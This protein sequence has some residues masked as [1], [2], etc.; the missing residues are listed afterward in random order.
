M[1]DL[2]NSSSDA[3]IRETL[4][5]LPEGL[6][7]TYKRILTKISKSPS[8]ALARKVFI[9]ATVAKRPLHVEELREAV[10][11]EPDDKSWNEDSIPHEDLMFECC[12]GLIIKDDDETA[13]FAHHTVQQYLTGGLAIKVDPFFQISVVNADIL[14]GQTCVAYLSF[15]DFETQITSSTPTVTPEHKGVLESGGPLWIPSI[16]GIRRPMFDI[17][18]RLLR[19]DP[20]MRPSGSDYWKHLRPKPKQKQNPSPD[21]KD[22]YRL[23]S[24]AIDYWEPHSRS[25]QLSDSVFPRRLENLAKH[26][27]LVFDFRPWGSNQHFGSYG[28]VGCPSPSAVNLVAKDLPHMSMIH[29]AAEVGNLPLLTSHYSSEIEI[30]DYI[31]HERYHHETLLIACRHNRIKIVRYLMNRYDS[32]EVGERAIIAAAAAGHAEVV[33]YLI[34]LRQYPVKQIGDV[35]LLLAA[36]NGHDAVVGVLAEAGANTNAYDQHTGRSIVESAAM[37][38]HDSVIRI[39]TRRGAQQFLDRNIGTKALRLAAANGHAT[40]TRVLLESRLSN[41]ETGLSHHLALHEAAKSGHSAV[42]EILL[43][44]GADPS[45]E[46]VQAGIHA[47]SYQETPFNLAAKSGHVRVLELFRKYVPSVDV[48]RRLTSKTALHY[49]AIGGHEQAIRW[50]VANGAD[51]NAMDH[52]GKTP[53]HFATARGEKTAVNVLL[54]L[55]AMVVHTKALYGA[56]LVLSKPTNGD[57]VILEL[58]LKN[59]RKDPRISDNSKHEAIL[60][61]LEQARKEK[62]VEFVEM[63]ER[64][65]KLYPEEFR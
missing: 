41:D 48:P 62:S 61:A 32:S 25:Y 51:V 24:Y 42:A 27:T 30:G 19:G 52:S 2:C 6:G 46:P 60:S 1:D 22:K 56:T 11:I 21:V 12:R 49:A 37:N 34:S 18:Y 43:E 5:N 10:A 14:A 58:L 64:E 15:S 9:W 36:K 45:F 59:L 16:L 8:R 28:C 55:G 33:H 44:Y 54:Q 20:A 40:V 47:D 38:G 4:K 17:P 63:L 3:M 13:H 23:L 53:L 31:Y 57:T 7:D 35:P 29:Y 26:K 39:L 50:L 65:Q